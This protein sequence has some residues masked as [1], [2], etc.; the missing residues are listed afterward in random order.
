MENT[1]VTTMTTSSTSLMMNNFCPCSV[2]KYLVSITCHQHCLRRTLRV[3]QIRILSIMIMRKR[4]R[5]MI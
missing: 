2:M 1:M 4:R 5:R 3:L